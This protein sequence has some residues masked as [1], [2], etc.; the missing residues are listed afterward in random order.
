MSEPSEPKDAGERAYPARPE[1]RRIGVVREE[2]YFAS[3]VFACPACGYLTTVGLPECPRCFSALPQPKSWVRVVVRSLEWAAVILAV[4][5]F[6]GLPLW[7]PLVLSI[8]PLIC[9]IMR[10]GAPH[11]P[12]QF[13]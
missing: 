5:W 1:V 13:R 10:P 4:G 9:E 7:V 2:P 12:A 11:H 8:G 3:P 6:L